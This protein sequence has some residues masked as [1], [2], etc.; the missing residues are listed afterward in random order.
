MGRM[1]LIDEPH[2]EPGVAVLE[3]FGQNLNEVLGPL[4]S[5]A[6]RFSAQVLGPDERKYWLW[7]V[8]ALIAVDLFYRCWNRPGSESFW[9]YSAPWRIHAHPS[10]VLDYKYLVVQKLITAFIIAP[11]LVSALALGNWGSKLLVSWLGPGPQWTPS[12]AALVVFAMVGLLLFDI[13]HYISHYV[14]H[15]VPFFWEFHKIHHAAEVLTP[16]TAFR[17][18]PVEIILDRVFQGPLQALGLAV[19][20]YLYGTRQFLD[21]FRGDKRHP[22]CSFLYLLRTPFFFFFFRKTSNIFFFPPRPQPPTPPRRTP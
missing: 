10:A 21:N 9:S 14:Q 4:A 6:R 16:V 7:L 13:G 19:F 8:G 5:L 15:K 2:R 22:S 18:H 11:M 20:Y 3:P 12:L 17:A 1:N